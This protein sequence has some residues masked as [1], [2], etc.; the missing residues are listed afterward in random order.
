MSLSSR[1]GVRA[2]SGS[3]GSFRSALDGGASF[4]LDVPLIPFVVSPPPLLPP[5]PRRVAWRAWLHRCSDA[6][7]KRSACIMHGPP[8]RRRRPCPLLNQMADPSSVRCRCGTPNQKRS[9]SQVH[10]E[11][12]R[13]ALHPASHCIAWGERRAASGNSACTASNRAHSTMPAHLSG[14]TDWEYHTAPFVY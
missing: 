10:V 3:V 11:F 5:P 9:V 12:L 1:A 4:V 8:S 7:E 14:S 6:T 2:C 13:S